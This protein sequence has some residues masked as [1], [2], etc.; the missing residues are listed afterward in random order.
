MANT[1]D[2]VEALAQKSLV[3]LGPGNRHLDE[4]VVISGHKMRLDDLRDFGK[5][6]AE[7]LQ[8]L[9]VMPVEN[10]LNK[11]T[12]GTPMILGSRTAT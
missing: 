11:T 12:F 2:P 1:R 3:M 10:D 4:I 6:L 9:L 8:H 7:L 5:S